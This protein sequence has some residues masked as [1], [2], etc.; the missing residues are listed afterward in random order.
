MTFQLHKSS[1]QAG[2]TR[3]KTLE[4]S[5]ITESGYSLYADIL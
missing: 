5:N 4:E 2:K 1:V 3:G